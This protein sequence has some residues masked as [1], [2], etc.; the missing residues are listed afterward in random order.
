MQRK[1]GGGGRQAPPSKK[2][3]GG[4]GGYTV[5]LGSRLKSW[6]KSNYMGSSI[7]SMALE[8]HYELVSTACV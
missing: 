3:K 6:C 4:G 1:E 8:G 5:C 2:R 7:N